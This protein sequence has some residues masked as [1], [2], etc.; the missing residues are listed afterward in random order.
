MLFSIGPLQR[1]IGPNA[2]WLLRL[3]GMNYIAYAF[4]VDFYRTPL[5]GGLKHVIQYLPFV[6]LALLGPSLRFAAFAK[7]VDR[8]LSESP[9]RMG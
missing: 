3:V 9:Y 4:F 1:A 2:W 6:T 8:L 5:D 7:R